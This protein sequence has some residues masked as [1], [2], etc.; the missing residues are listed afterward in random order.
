MRKNWNFSHLTAAEAQQPL[1]FSCCQPVMNEFTDKR[2]SRPI[3]PST[4][5]PCAVGSI[6]RIDFGREALCGQ[7]VS[8]VVNTSCEEQ[9]EDDRLL[10][11]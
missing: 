11:R 7:E 2:P 8:C 5:Q 9:A 10:C 6:D 1:A 4:S 3:S